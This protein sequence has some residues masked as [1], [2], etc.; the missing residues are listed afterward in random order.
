M[1][2]NK[3]DGMEAVG[4]LPDFGNLLLREGGYPHLPVPTMSQFANKADYEAA[5]KS[6]SDGW[7][8]TDVPP[9]KEGT[10]QTCGIFWTNLYQYWDGKTWGLL[11][12]DFEDA[13]K[14]KSVPEFFFPEKWRE[15]QL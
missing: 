8:D 7:N 15:V 14:N 4:E 3:I 11:V 1:N 12:A 2:Q 10:Y 5:I 6:Q 13:E 9:K